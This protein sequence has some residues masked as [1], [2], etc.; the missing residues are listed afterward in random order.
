MVAVNQFAANRSATHFYKPLAFLPER[1]LDPKA[2]PSFFPFASDQHDASRNFGGGAWDCIGQG[3]AW[4]EM[5]LILANLVWAF[6]IEAVRAVDWAQQK[7]YIIWQKKPFD[8]W[9]RRR[10]TVQE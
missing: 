6:D 9:L 7:T 1:W 4:A 5:R 10:V 2:T 3:I 8:V